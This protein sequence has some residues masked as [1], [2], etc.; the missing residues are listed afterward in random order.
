VSDDNYGIKFDSDPAKAN[1]T[2]NGTITLGVPSGPNCNEIGPVTIKVSTGGVSSAEYEYSGNNIISL[3]GNNTYE[4]YT[5]GLPS[6]YQGRVYAL[7]TAPGSCGGADQ[8]DGEGEIII[9][10]TAGGSTGKMYILTNKNN[11][12]SAGDD[13][14]KEF[15]E[16]KGIIAPGTCWDYMS[17]D[18]NK[19]GPQPAIPITVTG[20]L[21]GGP[22]VPP[23][24]G[25]GGGGG[26]AATPADTC[27]LS[28]NGFSLAWLMCPVLL[29]GEEISNNLINAFENE[30]S[31][32]VSQ[33]LGGKDSQAGVEKTWSLFKNI[34]T[35]ILV[36]L[37]LVMVFSQAVSIGPFD[38]YTVRKMLP[39]LVIVA[40]AIQLSW[41][42]V[43]FIIDRFDDIGRG[44]A[45]IMKFSFG[46]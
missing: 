10:G 38:A 20:Q 22:I 27:E 43:A 31:F 24:G 37:M 33:G 4:P 39:R 15:P 3:Q 14:V 29:A 11:G 41:P 42:L 1:S 12:F 18:V 23:G 17:L 32:N 45:N 5:S 34:A 40:I 21:G 44:I 28:S 35:A 25:T 7:G 13:A 46:G 2:I 30:L 6:N 8:N 19:G 9:M 26:D 36:I 16:L